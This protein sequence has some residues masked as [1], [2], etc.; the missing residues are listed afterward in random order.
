MK[1]L[2]VS[3]LLLLLTNSLFSQAYNNEFDLNLRQI[4]IEQQRSAFGLTDDEFKNLS[5]KELVEQRMNKYSQMGEY[6][7]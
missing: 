4:K 1:K 3:I 6:N 7:D 5:P 2:L